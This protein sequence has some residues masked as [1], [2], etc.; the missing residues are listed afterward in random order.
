MGKS[1]P[2]I[3]IGVLLTVIFLLWKNGCNKPPKEIAVEIVRVDT[4]YD[5]TYI[6]DTVVGDPEWV[7]HHYDTTIWIMEPENVP[8]STYDSLLAQYIALGNE[9]YSTNGYLTKFPIDTFGFV[10]VFDTIEANRLIS[11]VLLSDLRIPEKTIIVEKLRPATRQLYWG[12]GGLSN[13]S[14]VVNGFRA[15]LMYRDRK[16]RMFE[17]SGG[18]FGSSPIFGATFY[19]KF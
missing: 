13:G 8:A 12:I 4:L 16:D 7:Y 5:T 19:K 15:G 17:L 9:L 10:T 11:S 1:I 3:I 2:Y 18:I 6:H 14:Q